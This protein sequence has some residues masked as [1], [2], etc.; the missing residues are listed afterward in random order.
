MHSLLSCA[1]LALVA[2]WTAWGQTAAPLSFEVASVKPAI[3]GAPWR[4]SKT[5]IDRI[6]F[7][8]VTLR[9]CV[10]FAYGLK[11][12]QV[13]GPA[14]ITEL[15][16]D[17]VAKAPT[18]TKPEQLPGMMQTLLAERFQLHA[19]HE[20][21]EFDVM[22]LSIGKNGPK[23]KES[24]PLPEGAPEGA[25][26]G[27]SM[28][29]AIG[30]I[31]VRRGNMTSLANTLLRVLGRPVIDTTGLT[32]R[33]DFDLEF[34]RDDSNGSFMPVNSGG[35]LPSASEP[36]AS[37]FSSIQLVGLKLEPRKVPLDSIVVDRAEKIPTGN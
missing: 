36:G 18:G 8:N 17:I 27:L 20:T 9:S 13:S 10:A 35:A 6:D 26:I 31:E 37:V 25:K 34:S 7:P 12:Y 32:G 22:T 5:N 33:Y 29:N 3:P 19:H 24:P 21:K 1:L 15:K 11:E 14:W 28:N 30:R 23:L 4:E 16:Y 2:G